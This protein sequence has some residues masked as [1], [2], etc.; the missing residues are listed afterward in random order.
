MPICAPNKLA[1]QKEIL[2]EK[3]EEGRGGKG[4]IVLLHIIVRGKTET[5]C[6]IKGSLGNSRELILIQINVQSL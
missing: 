4:I 6:S 5:D 1:A 3:P 2:Y